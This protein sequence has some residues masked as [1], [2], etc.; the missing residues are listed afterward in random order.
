MDSPSSTSNTIAPSIQ[1]D[2]DVGAELEAFFAL[3]EEV[4]GI[5][6][7]ARELGQSVQNL[8]EKEQ[9]KVL[10]N[11][12]GHLKDVLEVDY[13]VIEAAFWQGASSSW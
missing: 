13:G 8:P 6:N 5:E 4:Q 12:Q 10:Q 9:E 2:S 3:E 1:V 7:D 11:L